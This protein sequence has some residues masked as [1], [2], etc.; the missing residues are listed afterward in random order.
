MAIKNGPEV[1]RD[2][3]IRNNCWSVK[4]LYALTKRMIGAK[5]N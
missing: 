1:L 4:W 5:E 3:R 2:F